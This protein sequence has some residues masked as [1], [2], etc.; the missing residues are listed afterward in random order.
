MLGLM[1]FDDSKFCI[2]HVK[3]RYCGWEIVE[4]ID[5]N[6]RNQILVVDVSSNSKY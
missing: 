4:I 3:R 1:M 2:T 5:I 6:S